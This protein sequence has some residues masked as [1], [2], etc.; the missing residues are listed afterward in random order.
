MFTLLAVW[1][2]IPIFLDSSLI[3]LR[4]WWRW[5]QTERKISTLSI[6]CLGSI[7]TQRKPLEA[8]NAWLSFFTLVLFGQESV[9]CINH[10]VCTHTH[11]PFVAHKY[12]REKSF[13]LRS[14]GDWGDMDF[15]SVVVQCIYFRQK[16]EFCLPALSLTAEMCPADA[17]HTHTHTYILTHGAAHCQQ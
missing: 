3:K 12:T 9:F 6:C 15:A 13:W 17:W 14:H 11:T 5:W 2:L 16:Y 4:A 1:G 10:S 8:R 7:V